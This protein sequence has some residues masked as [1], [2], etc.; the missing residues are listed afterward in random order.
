MI[1]FN[2]A[3]LLFLIKNIAAAPSTKLN[4]TKIAL[5][6]VI[7]DPQPVSSGSDASINA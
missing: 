6:P 7:A 4:V 2:F 5:V 3:Y 1:K